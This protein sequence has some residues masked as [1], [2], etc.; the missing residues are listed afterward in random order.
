[1]TKKNEKKLRPEVRRVVK[2]SGAYYVGIPK[3][4]FSHYGIQEGGH[5]A[6]VPGVEMYSVQPMRED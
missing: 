1:M 5:V 3:K 6:L 4:F 2:I